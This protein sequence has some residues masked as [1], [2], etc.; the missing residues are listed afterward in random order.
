MTGLSRSLSRSLTRSL[1]RPLWLVSISMLALLVPACKEAP[2]KTA[3]VDETA[4]LDETA[5]L[6]EDRLVPDPAVRYGELP[7]GLTYAL[8]SNATPSGTASLLLR[9]EAGSLDEDEEDRGLAHFLEHMA[10]NGSD[11]YPEGEL[12]PALERLGLAFG[13]D[14]NAYTTFDETVYRLELPNLDETVV[15][16]ALGAMRETAS[17]LTLDPD[18][19]DRERGV[20][21]SE[22]RAR[23]SPAARASEDSLN[24]YLGGTPYPER[25]PIGTEATINAVEA[26]AF[27]T[28]YAGRYRPETA[29]LVMVGDFDLDAMEA[30]IAEV[31]GDWEGQ[32]EALAIVRPDTLP[33]R[34][35]RVGLFIDPE[36]TTGV[37]VVTYAPYDDRPDSVA[38]RRERLI[39][40][41]GHALLNRRF[42]RIATEGSA[43]FLGGS[44]SSYPV[45]EVATA[46]VLGVSSVPG[47]WEPALKDGVV[48]L[49]KALR[50]CFRDSELAEWKANTRRGLERAIETADTR[51][52][53]GLASSILGAMTGERVLTTPESALARYSAYEDT[54]T[55]EVVCESFRAQWEGLETADLYLTDSVPP[56]SEAAVRAAFDAA[57]A[58]NIVDDEERVVAEFAYS[59]WGTPGEVVER[60][61]IA[62]VD[63]TRVRFANGV[64]LN[65]KTTPYAKDQVQARVSLGAGLLSEGVPWQEGLPQVAGPVMAQGGLQAHTADELRSI[66]AGSTV[67]S[68]MSLGTNYLSV[69]G[70]AAVGDLDHLFDLMAASVTANA[71]REEPVTNFRR[72]L[73]AFYETIDSTPSGVAGRD[74]PRLLRSG[75]A[76]WGVPEKSVLQSLQAS[77][78]E[79]VVQPI[80]ETASI[81]I[82][83]VGDVDADAVVAAVARTF[84]ALDPRPDTP[85][86]ED[87][88]KAKLAFPEPGTVELIHEGDPGTALYQAFFPAID[89]EDTPR[90]RA[91]QFARDIAQLKLTRV[92]R[93]REGQSYSPSV[94]SYLSDSFPDYGYVAFSVNADPGELDAIAELVDEVAGEMRDGRITEDELER[95]RA[96]AL[97]RARRRLESNGY[98]LGVIDRL[99]G[100][101]GEALDDHRSREEA[102]RNMTLADIKAIS[103][104]IFRP[105]TAFRVRIVPD[106]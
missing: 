28:F 91:A 65:V 4:A 67:G 23:K 10:F 5:D 90:V 82:G 73:D 88:L 103:A 93:E 69:N 53:P 33:E 20:I 26:E 97:Q 47:G 1:T 6:A 32:G 105:E 39:E 3:A 61:V 15:E 43:D 31:F 71:Y 7:N 18:A 29:T 8:R 89:G 36:I 24:F 22:L 25:L 59:D 9:F 44:V 100:D 75:D 56:K 19:I 92:L 96:P 35:P 37:N 34:E 81:E 45:F 48:E 101:G 13:A 76:R 42:A 64:R 87:E 63:V 102:Y 16:A 85:V 57:M 27:R 95:V 60:E 77:D 30:R 2:P 80:L 86:G 84:G 68:S 70:S 62:D 104:E 78:V 12:V 51:R 49:R 21:L 40:G 54:I 41:V 55:P 14:T 72:D 50:F 66:L 58:L 79:A 94:T 106:A 38:A 17:R 46:N 74:V 52:T 83:V 99:A 98:W 11:A